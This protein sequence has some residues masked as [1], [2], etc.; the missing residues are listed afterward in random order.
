MTKKKRV[1]GILRNLLKIIC[2]FI[3]RYILLLSCL[4]ASEFQYISALYSIRWN[5]IIYV[6]LLILTFVHVLGY[7]F[8][9]SRF[10]IL[11]PA[12]GLESLKK[13]LL[14]IWHVHM[15]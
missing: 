3:D 2:S 15:Y 4:A 7:S 10:C 1:R 9:D 8:L 13:K 12:A 6:S 5:S 14:H 11:A